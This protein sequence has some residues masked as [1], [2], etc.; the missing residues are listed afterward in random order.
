MKLQVEYD[1]E[2]M[3]LDQLGAKYTIRLIPVNG[4]DAKYEI[5]NT[6]PAGK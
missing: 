5:R 2:Q 6:T 3:T 1:T 4:E